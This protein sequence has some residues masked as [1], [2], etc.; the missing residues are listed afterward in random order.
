MVFRSGSYYNPDITFLLYSFAVSCD[1]GRFFFNLSDNKND[2]DF[3][4]DQSSRLCEKQ[5]AHPMGAGD[6]RALSSECCALV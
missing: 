2:H 3:N 5:K 4:P 1:C 6:S